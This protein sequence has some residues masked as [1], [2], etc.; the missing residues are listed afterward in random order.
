MG[1]QWVTMNV[2]PETAPLF[3]TVAV[4]AVI[5]IAVI[6]WWRSRRNTDAS[7]SERA[8][9]TAQQRDAPVEKGEIV[10]AGVEELSD[11]HSGRTDAVVTVE[12]FVVFVKDVPEEVQPADMLRVRVLSFNRKGTSANAKLLERL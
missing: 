10:E 4:V 7:R 5:G 12:G 8:H 6:L 1:E 9:R 2:P 11:H 3:G